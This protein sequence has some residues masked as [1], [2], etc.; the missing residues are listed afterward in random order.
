MATTTIFRARVPTDRLRR[1]EKIL[2][3]IGL[4]PSEAFNIFLA[5]VEEVG[6]FPLDIRPNETDELMANPDFVSHL[7]QLKEGKVTYTDLKD[8][9]V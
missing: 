1:A 6:G 5:K 9:P 2:S 4:K 3:K 7:R 8:L